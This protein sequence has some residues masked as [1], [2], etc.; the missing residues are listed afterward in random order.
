MPGLELVKLDAGHAVNIQ[1]ADDFNAAV[2]AFFA[3]F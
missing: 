2:S 3:R 1:S